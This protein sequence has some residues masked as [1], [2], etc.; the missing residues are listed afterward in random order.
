M[1]D[2][3]LFA[4]MIDRLIVINCFLRFRPLF[5]VDDRPLFAVDDRP[6][7]AVDDRPLFAAAAQK[8]DSL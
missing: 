3:P 6:L 2:R 5:A 8:Y 4:V 1:D 7:F